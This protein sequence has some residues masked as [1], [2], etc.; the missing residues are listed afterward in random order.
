MTDKDLPIYV[1][2]L[3]GE[4][5][6]IKKRVS[7]TVNYMECTRSSFSYDD[8]AR[9]MSVLDTLVCSTSEAHNS[10]LDFYNQL[11]GTPQQ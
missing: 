6:S 1:A 9:L 10:F 3:S 4:L 8:F 11:C 5:A 2:A 7:E